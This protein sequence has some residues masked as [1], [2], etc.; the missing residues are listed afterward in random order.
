MIGGNIKKLRENK[1]IS[2]KGFA[3]I[4]DI[5]YEY[6]NKI[7]NGKKDNPSTKVMQKIANAL[8]CTLDELNDNE[9]SEKD[10]FSSDIGPEIRNIKHKI[11]KNPNGPIMLN[12]K[13]ISKKKAEYIL[14][15]F[16]ILEEDTKEEK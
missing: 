9:L 11:K 3:K 13:K 2:Q 7:E 16:G 14:S 5:S 15:T 1:G 12:G 8:G 4:V 10:F 6:L